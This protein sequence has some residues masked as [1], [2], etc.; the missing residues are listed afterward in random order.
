[1]T[2]RTHPYL[3]QEKLIEYSKSKGIHTTA[4][5]ATGELPLL[6]TGSLLKIKS[7]RVLAGD[8]LLNE[9][10]AKYKVSLVQ[11]IFA[12][13]MAREVSFATQSSNEERRKEAL[14]VSFSTTGL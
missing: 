1:M 14:N 8:A 13:N 10:A 7:G 2:T 5:S 12:W 3:V 6:S 9:L 4:F 11:I